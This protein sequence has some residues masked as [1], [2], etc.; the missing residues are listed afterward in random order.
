[1][2]SFW[3]SMIDGTSSAANTAAN[4]GGGGGGVSFNATIQVLNADDTIS[5]RH[6][7]PDGGYYDIADSNSYEEDGSLSFNLDGSASLDE[8]NGMAFMDAV[9]DYVHENEVTNQTNDFDT[10][11]INDYDDSLI[12][13]ATALHQQDD[14]DEFDHQNDHGNYFHSS[15]RY[16]CVRFESHIDGLFLSLN[17]AFSFRCLLPPTTHT[18][19]RKRH[20]NDL[21]ASMQFSDAFEVPS[22]EMDDVDDYGNDGSFTMGEIM[23]QKSLSH[24]DATT[25]QATDAATLLSDPAA[26]VAPKGL[27]GSVYDSLRNSWNRQN[28]ADNANN[29]AS[30]APDQLLQGSMS[31]SGQ[32]SGHMSMA[33]STNN[34]KVAGAFLPGKSS[35]YVYCIESR[36]SPPSRWTSSAPMS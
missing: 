22:D 13:H 6:M 10:V 7:N 35:V 27:L 23:Q 32:V 28:D 12:D 21:N 5:I 15:A 29:E 33:Q 30:M 9:Q 14:M 4:G 24:M 17:F 19:T 25:E 34:I 16:V 1:M 36:E 26:A 8:D 2:M 31:E 3:S 20:S 11:E 18:R